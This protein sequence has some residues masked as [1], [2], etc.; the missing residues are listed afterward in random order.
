RGHPRGAVRRR[1]AGGRGGVSPPPDGYLGL[2]SNLGEREEHLRGALAGLRAHGVEVQAVSSVY[3][4]EPVGEIID[5][6]TFLNAVACIA[7]DLGPHALLDLCKAIEAE[8][9]RLFGAPR[10]GPRPPH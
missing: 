9:A 4:T 8:N 3:E 10:H 1:R 2:G 7:T 5:Q 6:P